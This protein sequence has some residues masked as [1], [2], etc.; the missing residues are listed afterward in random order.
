MR[1]LDLFSGLGGF[2]EAFVLA[3][4]EVKR[5]ENNPLLNQVPDTEEMCVL[6]L[7]DILQ[8][9]VN[10]GNFIWPIDVL[11]ASPPCLEFSFGFNAPQSVAARDGRYDE[12]DP[13][14]S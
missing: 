13:S 10:Q 9:Q 14:R 6:E 8:S 4:D 1:V 5:I 12:Y 2:S 11:L 7:R 3:G